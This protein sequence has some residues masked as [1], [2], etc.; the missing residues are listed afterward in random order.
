MFTDT[1]KFFYSCML[2]QVST[3]ESN[4]ALIKLFTKNDPLKSVHS[5]TAK[6]CS[7]SCSLFIRQLKANANGLQLQRNV[8]VFYVDQKV[9]L[10][11]KN[12]DLLVCSYHKPLLK[13]LQVILIMK[14]V[15][16]GASK[17]Q[18]SSAMLRYNTLRE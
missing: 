10:L 15:M 7:P 18:L 14:N 4:K 6:F 5:Q 1:S 11:V 12:L 3:D 8:L 9:F 13:I 17:L 2:T 16:H